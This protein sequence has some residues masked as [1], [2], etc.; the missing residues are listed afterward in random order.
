MSGPYARTF[1]SSRCKRAP[2]LPKPR[3]ALDMREEVIAALVERFAEGGLEAACREL[4]ATS[5]ELQAARKKIGR[6][7]ERLDDLVADDAG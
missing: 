4:A 5:L 3:N 6:L 7:L 2:R 1:P